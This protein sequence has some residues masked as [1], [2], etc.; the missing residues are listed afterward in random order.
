M[1]LITIPFPSLFLLLTMSPVY[2]LQTADEL[3]VQAIKEIVNPLSSDNSTSQRLLMAA[4]EQDPNHPKAMWQLL[5]SRLRLFSYNINSINSRTEKLSIAA[6]AVKLIIENSKQRN[7]YAFADYV[8]ARYRGLYNDFENAL[9]GINQAIENEPDS[10]R[11]LYTKGIILIDKGKWEKN[12]DVV[13]EGM[14]VIDQ[15]RIMAEKNPSIYFNTEDYYFKLAYTNS[16]LIEKKPEKTLEHYFSYLDHE[17]DEKSIARAWNNI[18]IAYQKLKQCEK[19]REAAEKA[20]E[21]MDF[22][23]ARSNLRYSEFCQKMDEMEL[24]N[25]LPQ[26]KR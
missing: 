9:T 24:L 2:A 22:G 6:Q 15:A 25:A 7:D 8:L 23:A 3:Y 13:V 16:M 18:S 14:H 12:D 4:L 17:T 19:A 10:I 20:L 1:K 21:I 5:G 26:K 11:Y